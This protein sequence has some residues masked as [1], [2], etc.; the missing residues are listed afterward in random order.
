MKK[1]LTIIVAG[2]FA[3]AF[4]QQSGDPNQTQ[5]R[6]FEQLKVEAQQKLQSALNEI[7]PEVKE[8]VETAT[9]TAKQVQAQMKRDPKGA[10]TKLRGDR[11]KAQQQLEEAIQ[12]LEQVSSLVGSQVDKVKAEIQ[13]RLK[14]KTEELK[15]LQ[16]RIQ[17]QKGGNPEK[18]GSGK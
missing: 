15:Q 3:V 8:Q 16:T 18:S 2:A 9:Q 6:E 13:N 17:E 12:N 14:E 10:A 4:A 1:L 11:A 7:S 5:A